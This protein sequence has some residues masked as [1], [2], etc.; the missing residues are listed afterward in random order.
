MIVWIDKFYVVLDPIPNCRVIVDGISILKVRSVSIECIF[1]SVSECFCFELGSVM[2]LL[3]IFRYVPE[4]G[5]A[6][7]EHYIRPE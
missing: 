1:P 4:D 2:M 7:P 3:F 5:R 6:K